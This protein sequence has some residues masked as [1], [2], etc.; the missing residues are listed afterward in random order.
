[1]SV[2]VNE[3]DA[4]YEHIMR[5]FEAGK[6]SPSCEMPGQATALGMVWQPIKE[7]DGKETKYKFVSD[8]IAS[9]ELSQ[10]ANNSFQSG[11]S[12]RTTDSALEKATE[13]EAKALT[14]AEAAAEKAEAKTKKG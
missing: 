13:L 6:A 1:M 9:N 7:S 2:I 14:D 11:K 8:T 10:Y 4:Q 12:V 3:G 5:A